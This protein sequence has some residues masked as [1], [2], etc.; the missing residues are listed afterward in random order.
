[1]VL[2]YV[3]HGDPIYDPDSLTELGYEQAE[4]V[5][6]RMVAFAPDEIYASTS[7]RAILTAKPTCE[8]LGKE[9]ILLDFA[10]EHYAWAELSANN[11]WAFREKSVVKIL[12]T[13][14]VRK[15]GHDW[16]NHPDLLQYNFEKG[17][18]R[19]DNAVDE[20]LLCLGYKHDRKNG[21]YEIVVK[22]DKKVALFAHAGFGLAFFSSVLDIPYPDFA[23]RFDTCHTGI[24]VIEFLEYG[25][26]VLPRVLTLSNDSH[27]YKNGVAHN[28]YES[29]QLK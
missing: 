27:L 16:Y 17:I 4:A 9:P 1:M 29:F 10:N 23:M 2:Y 21:K 19:I 7:N 11:D 18:K 14:E 15:M 24:T 13:E 28:F 3:R 6:E 5:S 25:D 20:W 22:N 26:V 8:K 12:A